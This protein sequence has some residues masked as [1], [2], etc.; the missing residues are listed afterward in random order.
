MRP[1]NGKFAYNALLGKGKTRPEPDK[2]VFVSIVGHST[3]DYP[4]VHFSASTFIYLSNA[5]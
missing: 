2:S 4:A 1:I 3:F 5:L